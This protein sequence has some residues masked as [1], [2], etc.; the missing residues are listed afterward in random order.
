MFTHACSPCAQVYKGAAVVDTIHVKADKKCTFGL[1][2]GCNMQLSHLSISRQHATIAAD[3]DCALMLEDLGSTHGCVLA[4]GVVL[5]GFHSPYVGNPTTL[6]RWECVR[7]KARGREL[8]RLDTRAAT[9]NQAER[10]THRAACEAA[11]TPGL[12]GDVRRLHAPVRGGGGC[13]STR[14]R[15]HQGLR[16]GQR[17]GAEG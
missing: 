2:P 15:L 6:L 14:A 17:R 4:H 12:P 3:A 1:H 7:V 11:A 13:S 8:T 5:R 10:Q 9:Q 16:V